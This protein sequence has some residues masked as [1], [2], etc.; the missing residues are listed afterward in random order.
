MKALLLLLPIHIV[1]G[2]IALISGFVGVFVVKGMKV[3]RLS[4][5]IFLYAMLSLGIS[6]ALIAIIKW[7]PANIVGGAIAVYMV[8][9]GVLTL[10]GRDDSSSLIDAAGIA[11]AIGIV[12]FSLTIGLRVLHS[13][14]GKID[15][16]PPTPLFAFAGVT[17]L[18]ILGDL[19]VMIKRGLQGRQRLIRHLWRMCFS[20]FIASG[21]FFIGQAKVIPRPIRIF[22]LL[23]IPAFLPLVLLLYWVARVSLTQWYRRRA[24]FV[25][26]TPARG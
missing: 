8:A 4:G 20:L 10:R 11:L 25:R 22:P 3:H 13:P 5:R 15:G 19:R 24:E 21:S 26:P 1:S 7:Q 2:S 6:G 23:A 17:L 14:S 12:Y 9:T 18:A 16:V